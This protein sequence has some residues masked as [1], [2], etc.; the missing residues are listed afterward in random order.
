MTTMHASPIIPSDTLARKV[1]GGALAATKG[2]KVAAKASPTQASNSRQRGVFCYRNPLLS[3]HPNTIRS[4]LFAHTQQ[5]LAERYHPSHI[6]AKF[7]KRLRY[8]PSQSGYAL[9]TLLPVILGLLALATIC[10]RW[11]YADVLNTQIQYHLTND[12]ANTSSKNIQ[13]WQQSKQYLEQILSLRPHYPLYFETAELFFQRLDSLETDAPELI[14]ALGWKQN[15]QQALHYARLGLQSMPSWPYLWKELV[16]SKIT[17]NQFD[18][19]LSVAYAKAN[20]LG[21]WEKRLQFQLAILALENWDKLDA[22]TRLNSLQAVN[23]TLTIPSNPKAVTQLF[24]NHI[25]MIDVCALLITLPPNDYPMLFALCRDKL[26]SK[27]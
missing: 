14:S 11:S 13:N 4:G 18:Q 3:R 17:L 5:S 2:F 8:C 15:E 22:R 19:E 21:P 23:H 7:L 26:N 9:F 24:T 25:K 10:F 20:A 27:S 6:D 1:V 12:N 16:L